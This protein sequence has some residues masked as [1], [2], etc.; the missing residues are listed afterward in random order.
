MT[1]TYTMTVDMTFVHKDIDEKEVMTAED[2]KNFYK[3]F[4]P[5][6]PDDI[7]ARNFKQFISEEND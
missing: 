7:K 3:F 4:G 5:L 2:F 1:V 6:S